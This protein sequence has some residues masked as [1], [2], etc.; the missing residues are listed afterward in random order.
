M[1]GIPF[2]SSMSYAEWVYG[3]FKNQS[4]FDLDILILISLVVCYFTWNAWCQVS[5]WQKIIPVE[6]LV[7][8]TLGEVGKIRGLEKDRWRREVWIKV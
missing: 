2:L 6:V 5:L 1:L 7:S 8:D 3:A 4:G